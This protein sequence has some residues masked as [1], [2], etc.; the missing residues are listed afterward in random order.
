MYHSPALYYPS[1]F[2]FSGRLPPRVS[3]KQSRLPDVA[4][5]QPQHRNTIESEAPASVRRATHPE[6]ID[7]VL[8]ALAVRIQRRL[9]PTHPLG[10]RG[11]VVDTLRA[12]NNLLA[13]HEGIVRVRK[14]GVAGVEMRIEGARGGGVVR[15]EVEVCLVLLEDEPAEGFLIGGAVMRALAFTSKMVRRLGT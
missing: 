14:R 8:E 12:G 11:W 6:R 3:R 2:P 4:E 15:E 13:A 1:P 7:V 5:A 10:Q 9:H